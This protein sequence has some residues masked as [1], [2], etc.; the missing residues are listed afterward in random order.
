M[1]LAKAWIFLKGWEDFGD[2]S[3]VRRSH[4]PSAPYI[5]QLKEI[6]KELSKDDVD[7][8]ILDWQTNHNDKSWQRYLDSHAPKNWRDSV[9]RGS[10]QGKYYDQK[11]YYYKFRDFSP[12]VYGHSPSTDEMVEF[13]EGQRPRPPTTEHEPKTLQSQRADEQQALIN[14]VLQVWQ[15]QEAQR[16][17][18]QNSDDPE[19]Q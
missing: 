7:P 16:L 10:G 19:N 14:R 8:H 4:G 12:Q 5:A 1:A 11:N 6:I 18:E 17:R 2:E 13:I 15:D 3:H 9:P